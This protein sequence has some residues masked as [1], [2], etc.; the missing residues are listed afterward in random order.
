MVVRAMKNRS[1]SVRRGFPQLA[2]KVGP[3]SAGAVPPDS[4]APWQPAHDR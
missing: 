3:V 4:D 1:P 2:S